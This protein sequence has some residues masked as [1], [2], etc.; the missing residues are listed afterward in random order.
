MKKILSGLLS[1]AMVVSMTSVPALAAEC[2]QVTGTQKAY[3]VGDDWG[4]AVTKTVITLD[5]AVDADSLDKDDFTVMET[6]EGMFG[7]G[8]PSE[9]S[10]LD[11]YP[12]DSEG[13][14]V[15]GDSSVIAIEMAVD[16][17][18][19]SPFVYKF[20]SG[21]NYWCSTYELK[22][23][24][25]EGSEVR[26]AD[27]AAV[28]SFSVDP[29]IDLKG[30][31]KI[32][33]QVDGVFD[34]DQKYTAADGTVYN[35]ADYAPAADDKENALVIWLHGAGEGTDNGVNDSYIDLLGNE[36]TALVSDEFQ[37]LFGGA[38]VLVPQ[39]ATMWM[40]GGDGG[41]QNGDK[42][43]RYAESLFEFIESYV[44]ANPDI[45][46]D[47][48]LIG[49]CS[50]GGY[51]TMEMI[52]KHPDYFAA[53]FPIC[54][55]F[56]DEYITDEQIQSLVDMPIWFT[57][58][59]NDTTVDPTKCAEPTIERL[60][61][62]GAE[63]V[64]VSAF[65]D[66]HDTTG[67]FFNADGTPY[68]YQGHW[69]WTYFDNNE[70]FDENGVNAWEWLSEQTNAV[71]ASGTQRAYIIGDD[72]GPAVTKTVI[73]LDRAVDAESLRKEDFS[74]MEA[75]ESMFGGIGDPV[76]REVLDVY[77]SDAEGNRIEGDSQT[78]AVEMYVDP[79]TGSPFIY[80]FMQGFNY[81]C[82]TYEL[83][84]SL[85]AD[86]TLKFADG[87]EVD[88]LAVDPSIDLKGSG[89]IV[90][91]VDGVFDIDQKYTASDGTVYNYADYTPEED[92]KENALVIWLHGAGEGTDNGVN[93]SYIDLLGNEVTA[94]VSDEFQDLFGGAYVLV[95]QA[96]TMWMDGGDGEYQN[97]DKGS[98]YTESLFEFI[99][100]YVE[101][102]T[103]IDADRILIGGCSNGG[104]MTMEMIIKH[105]DYF[106]AAFPICEAFQDEYITDEQIESL[107]DMP[108]WF[109]YAKND[110]TVDP[111]K[112]TE[113][114]VER[115]LA[116]GAEN[117]HVSA[118]DDVHDTTGRFFNE[119]GTPYTYQGHWSWTYFDNNECYDENGVNAWEW[120]A[121]QTKAVS[122][123]QPGADENPDDGTDPSQKPGTSTPGKGSD[124]P[125]T[126]DEFSVMAAVLVLMLSAGVIVVVRKRQSQQ[127]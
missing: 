44:E 92:D 64:H 116:A 16:P 68:S 5:Q 69:S 26:L 95:P 24:L 9:R 38:Y 93:D 25:N 74:V 82:E 125:K 35:Y 101:E 80:K 90:P 66:V 57:Y 36:V 62:A 54:E 117:V 4:P 27:G 60:L 43:S 112:C 83:Q 59:K 10:V 63:N 108:I 79:N 81:W 73:T 94:L 29:V 37:D 6:K 46:T 23:T 50:N 67:R 75:K 76:A 113:P 28:E 18:T 78:I 22:V 88:M 58:A 45:D 34:I 20:T 17:N 103:D 41:Y 30:D 42:G 1:A 32:V 12:S 14:R 127:L 121:K 120:L 70:C 107:V 51:M 114:T 15:E 102:N 21:F 39:A 109:T 47:R 124:A 119:D 86:S 55:A 105:P 84:V 7:V 122:T 123:E 87:T 89:K 115:L 53:A 71:V 77:P 104:Y 13:S 126:G 48:I 2:G 52:I 96:A 118:F 56:Y 8:E 31:G 111:T 61:A 110:T 97:G 11:V 33:P 49:G 40:D 99:E 98:R 91:Q 19:G 100:S 85:N 3:I 106:A 65:D 72:W